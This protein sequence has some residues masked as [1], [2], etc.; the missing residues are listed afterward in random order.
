[1]TSTRSQCRVGEKEV[2]Q[3]W[4][5][6]EW[7]GNIFDDETWV[8]ASWKLVL[9]WALEH[10]RVTSIIHQMCLLCKIKRRKRT[11]N[12]LNETNQRISIL[13]GRK[14]L[15]T[16][17]KGEASKKPTL[18]PG[19]S[20]APHRFLI[21][22]CSFGGNTSLALPYASSNNSKYSILRW[23]WFCEHCTNNEVRK[24]KGELIRFPYWFDELSLC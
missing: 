13:N 9:S 10:M 7:G 5:T 21:P 20:I 11:G 23:T 4:R 8:H 19:T 16:P 15:R 22:S 14:H 6:R 1:M 18:Y 3:R 17:K 12:F 24:P 2:C